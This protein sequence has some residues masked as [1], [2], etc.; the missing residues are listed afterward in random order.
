[1][2]PTNLVGG[3]AY[4]NG[5]AWLVESTTPPSSPV[6]LCPLPP[7]FPGVVVLPSFAAL[8]LCEGPRD[9][10]LLSILDKQEEDFDISP[11]VKMSNS[12][13]THTGTKEMESNSMNV[14]S[15]DE[16]GSNSSPAS[17]QQTNGAREEATNEINN[18]IDKGNNNLNG[19]TNISARE[20]ECNG[21]QEDPVPTNGIKHMALNNGTEVPHLDI[22]N[23]NKPD[24]SPSPPSQSSSHPPSAQANDYG[25]RRRTRTSSSGERVE[26]RLQTSISSPSG[27][28]SRKSAESPLSL[29]SGGSPTYKRGVE[30]RTSRNNMRGEPSPHVSPH[31]TADGSTS[32]PTRYNSLLG[33]AYQR[34]SQSAGSLSLSRPTTPTLLQQ[35]DSPRSGSPDSAAMLPRSASDQTP[36]KKTIDDFTIGRVLGEGSYGAVVEAVDKETGIQYAIKILEKKHILKENKVKY[37]TTERDILGQCYHPGIVKLFY[38][39]RSEASLYYVLELCPHELLAHI[40]QNGG[41]DEECVRFYTAEIV[42]ALEYLHGKGVVHRDLKPENILLSADW[43]VKLCDFGTAK[44]LGTERNARSNSFVGTAE[45][46]SPELISTKETSCASDLWALGSI[47]YQMCANRLPF[48][49]KTEF[50]TFQKVTSR[51][52][53]FPINFPPDAKDLVENL[54]ALKPEERIGSRAGGFEELKKHRFFKGIAWGQLREQKPP[55]LK[56]P[57]LTPIFDELSPPPSPTSHNNFL[58]TSSSNVLFN[59][60]PTGSPRNR[61]NSETA[62]WSKFLNAD[63][64]VRYMGLVWKRKGL[65]IK[66]RHL[67]LTNYPRLLYID[68]KKMALRGEI[69]WSEHLRPELKSTS[70]FYVHT[71]KRKYILEDTSNNATKWVEQIQ[72]AIANFKSSDV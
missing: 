55:P 68:P 13:L 42:E 5:C 14:K 26:S 59:S 16:H 12:N 2:I 37:V 45:Y 57:L 1:M 10:R 21:D 49:G 58:R 51:D 32:S 25:I 61:A 53:T 30:R 4:S 23:N 64:S 52:L 9:S 33:Q 22:P 18:N 44:I 6:P 46:V 41:L 40:K 17:F 15:S 65:S 54:L 62:K 56:K 60:S 70:N 11:N 24:P 8:V 3:R 63:E 48:R 31:M 71:P 66:K 72:L 47:V 39:F 38:T 7:S 69:P 20:D 50:L 28:Y 19:S 43:H 67:I 35:G 36:K 27:M 29:S 34:T